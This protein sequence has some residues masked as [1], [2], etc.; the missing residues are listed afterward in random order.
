M[1]ADSWEAFTALIAAEVDFLR[2][3]QSA[4]LRLTDALVLNEPAAIDLAQR[5]LEIARVRHVQAATQR[6]SMQQRGFGTLTLSEV[7]AYAPPEQGAQIRN[8]V[9]AM[10]YGLTALGIT[11]NNNKAL[12]LGGMDRL[13]KVVSVIQRSSTEQTGTYRRRGQIPLTD[14]SVLVS[15]RA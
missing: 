2:A 14:G 9:A 13:A 10:T 12:I 4:A 8:C 11:N 5:E 3:L 7:A 1:S 6:R 15:R